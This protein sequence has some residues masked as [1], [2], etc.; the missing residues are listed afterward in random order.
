MKNP[1]LKLY[2]QL[3][4]VIHGFTRKNTK[5]FK[6]TTLKHKK[7]KV[8]IEIPKKAINLAVAQISQSASNDDDINEIEQAVSRCNE[9]EF[10]EIDISEEDDDMLLRTI[11]LRK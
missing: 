2:S 4:S 6:N 11:V 1:L 8:Q 3:I 5:L 10:T 9:E 7:M